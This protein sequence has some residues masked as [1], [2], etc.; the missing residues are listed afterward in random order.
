VPGRPP[1][2]PASIVELSPVEESS[3]PQ[4]MN[5]NVAVLTHSAR[6]NEDLMGHLPEEKVVLIG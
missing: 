6:L 2:I 1:S 4:A 5:K 3:P